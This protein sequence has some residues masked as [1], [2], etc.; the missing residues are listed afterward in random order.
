MIRLIFLFALGFVVTWCVV[1]FIRR[2]LS[3]RAIATKNDVLQTLIVEGQKWWDEFN[4]GLLTPE[5]MR[6]KMVAWVNA[7]R[8]EGQKQ[9]TQTLSDI[10]KNIEFLSNDRIPKLESQIKKYESM[11]KSAKKNMESA[12]NDQLKNAAKAE[13]VAAMS[14][15]IECQKSLDER[16][17]RLIMLKERA[18]MVRSQLRVFYSELESVE[19]K[20]QDI[21]IDRLTNN[22]NVDLSAQ[23]GNLLKGYRDAVIEENIKSEVV[24]QTTKNDVHL[25]MNVE[26]AEDA[27]MNL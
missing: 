19:D 3:A 11:A 17:E 4:K 2:R 22:M 14:R 6:D 23:F 5:I 1:M 20:I 21:T 16:K 8:D 10:E 24:N 25:S 13:G 12:V 15:M 27:F 7:M 18:S 9:F 26:G